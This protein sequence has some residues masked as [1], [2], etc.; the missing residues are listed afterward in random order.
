MRTA[1]PHPVD[2]G[3]VAAWP[4]PEQDGM[5]LNLLPQ[6]QQQHHQQ[7]YQQQ[8]QQEVQL[9]QHQMEMTYLHNAKKYP[10][11]ESIFWQEEDGTHHR[12]LQQQQNQNWAYTDA[13]QNNQQQQFEQ[14]VQS[15][16]GIGQTNPGTN[17]GVMNNKGYYDTYSANNTRDVN[18]S[19]FLTALSLNAILFVVLIGSYELFRR[20]FPSVYSTRAPA[21]TNDG[22]PIASPLASPSLAAASGVNINTRHF[23]GWV[24][25]VINASWSSVRTNGGLDSYMFLRYVRLCF[26][27]TFTSALWGMIILWP[28]YATGDGGAKGW[29]FLSMANL[30]QGSQ[31]LWVPTAFIWLQTM[32]VIFLMSEEYKHYLE[33]RVDFLARGEG[34]V[35][36]QQHMYSLIV[37]RIP[38]DLRSD[39]ALFDYFNRLFPGKI[40]ST[41]VVLNL[42]DLERVCQKRKRVLRRLEKSMVSLEV[43]GRRPRHVVGR[44]RLICCGI[45]S[46]PIF[47]SIGGKNNTDGASLPDRM[48]ERGEKVDSI[49]YYSRELTVM[50]ERVSRIQ[51]EKI[52]L[53]QKGNDSIRASQWISHAIDR[54]STA[55]ES[56]L[57]PPSDDGLI[58]GFGDS[59]THRRKP[60]LL[61]ILDRMGIDF[62]SGAINYV[63]Q[64][65][66]EVVDSVVGVTMSSTGFITFK[67]LSTLACAVKTPLFHKPDVLVVKMAPEPRDIIWEN[68]HVNLAWSKGREWTANVL[69][70]LGAILWSV[71]VASI[72]ALATA[73]QIATVPGMAWINTL[74]GGEVA[75]FVNGYLPVVLLL[76]IIM[77]LPHIFYAVAL[78]YEDRKTASDVQKSIIGRYFYYQLANIF[79]TVTAG[80]ILDSLGEIIEH[81]SNILAILGKSLPNVVG[82]FATFIMTKILAG[83][84]TILLRFPALLR[85]LFIK[86]CFREKYLTQAEIDES[87][88]PR[89]YAHIWYGWEYPNLLLVIVICFVYACISPVILP[90]GA[91]FFLGAWL[92]YKNQIL[93]VFNP[94][95][96]SGGTMFPMACHRT[97]IGLVCGQLTLIGYSIMRLGF[98]QALMMLPLPLITVKMMDVF[99]TL[100]EIPGMCISV[101]QAVELDAAKG[102]VQSSF[103]ADVY[104]QPVLTEKVVEP[105]IR[106]NPSEKTIGSITGSTPLEMADSGKIV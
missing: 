39:R 6:E 93:I 57:R 35:T 54:V 86:I 4:N 81:P 26:R 11:E 103:S 20:W 34:M 2:D 46:S 10:Q 42:P 100:Y 8:Q 59:S 66:D 101:E 65:I 90:V 40:H 98:Y 74:N 12:F 19:A 69:L 27:I 84:P 60:L 79:I 1:F 38:H 63:Q 95:Y 88:Y 33:C 76:T 28:V 22:V 80:S 49:N 45:E 94:L 99:K 97:L 87:Y 41:A 96:E 48:P 83:L 58:T 61:F 29:Y 23:L 77:I 44:K 3:S 70:G 64:N 30:S 62:I 51:R 72:Q 56:T 24:P 32:Y 106:R 89:K 91:S 31:R 36:S 102:G 17:N 75:N 67:D 9:H 85:M 21:R 43:K 16:F 7:Q 50:N 5:F 68:A 105:Q 92:V 25:G 47:S 82:Y 104:R 15:M 18:T 52:E 73:D 13:S 71:P 78:H 53:A 55:A 14:N 37:E